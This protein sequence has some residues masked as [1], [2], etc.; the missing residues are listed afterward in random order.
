MMQRFLRV[1]LLA[2]AAVA[3]IATGIPEYSVYRSLPIKSAGNKDAIK[4]N[5]QLKVS[6][7]AQNSNWD[8]ILHV[9][10]EIKRL[11]SS[12]SSETIA[13]GATPQL[14]LVIA[15]EDVSDSVLN[16]ALTGASVTPE[17]QGLTVFN[18]TLLGLEDDSVFVTHS[19]DLFRDCGRDC[20]SDIRVWAVQSNAASDIVIQIDGELQTVVFCV[21]ACEARELDELHVEF[22]KIETRK[23][24]QRAQF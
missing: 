16:A 2:L 10:L 8:A 11:P 15:T 1:T 5:F 13:L 23:D 7:Q 22:R 12:E 20:T 24:E 14:R 9:N 17:E 18:H 21:D 4:Q 19:F 3:S 6:P